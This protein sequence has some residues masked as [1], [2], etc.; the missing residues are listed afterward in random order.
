M[1]HHGCKTEAIN[2][3]IISLSNPENGERELGTNN[4]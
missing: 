2:K 4:R 1:I 3:S